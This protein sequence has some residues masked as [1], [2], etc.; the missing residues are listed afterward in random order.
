MVYFGALAVVRLIMGI[1]TA[2][3][4]SPG[5]AAN[6]QFKMIPNGIGT[7]FGMFLC[8]LVGKSSEYVLREIS[9]ENYLRFSSSFGTHQNKRTLGFS[10]I[11]H[12]LVA[13]STVYFLVMVAAQISVQV[14]VNLIQVQ[15][16]TVH[17]LLR[18]DDT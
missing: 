13:S 16:P 12:R 6:T 11:P 4:N 15:F 18:G 14:S 9:M 7:T 2:F 17:S 8:A 10:A 1:L 3:L 5:V